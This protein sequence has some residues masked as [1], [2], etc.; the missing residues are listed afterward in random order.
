MANYQSALENLEALV[1]QKAG[2]QLQV[3]Q[4][5]VLSKAS[6]IVVKRDLDSLFGNYIEKGAEILSIG[7]P[8]H[9]AL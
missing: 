7:D 5:T 9:K 3:D 4:L 6:G 8:L 2:K 1:T